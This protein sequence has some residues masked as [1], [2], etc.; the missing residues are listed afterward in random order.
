MNKA[1][2]RALAMIMAVTMV[3]TLIPAETMNA[4]GLGAGKA[5]AAGVMQV[6][7]ADQLSTTSDLD[8]N[9]VLTGKF[10][11]LANS[12]K[13]AAIKK[14]TDVD[15]SYTNST[16]KTFTNTV[17]LTGGGAGTNGNQVVNVIKFSTDAAANGVVYAA[18]KH[19]STNTTRTLKIYKATDNNAS[20]GDAVWTSE[21]TLTAKVMTKFEFSLE[22]AGTYYIGF[23]GDGGIIPYI[24]LE[25]A[26]S[27]IPDPYDPSDIGTTDGVEPSEAGDATWNFPVVAGDR[28]TIEYNG[29]KGNYRGLQIDATTG[30]FAFEA[31]KTHV[32]LTK[33][34]K[35]LVPVSGK[36]EITV[37]A[38]A[39]A[40]YALYTINGEAAS[41][42]EVTS[43]VTYDGEAGYVEIVSTGNAY[44]KS[45][46]VK[47]IDASESVPQNVTITIKDTLNLLDASDKIT[48]V[49]TADAQDVIEVSNGGQVT[50]MTNTTYKAVVQDSEGKE[51]DRVA[52][53][54]GDK[55]TVK[56]TAET[57]AISIDVVSTVVSVTPTITGDELGENKLYAV[58]GSDAMLLKNGEA[59]ILPKNTE[60][61]LVVK[62]AA[63][64][65]LK[66]WVATTSGDS[67]KFNTGTEEILALSV[68][69]QH[70]TDV[71][72]TPVITGKGMLGE[73]KVYMTSEENADGIEV[74]SGQKLTLKALTSYTLVIKTNDGVE[75]KDFEATIAASKVYTTG[76]AAAE[77]TIAVSVPSTKTTPYSKD[78][79]AKVNGGNVTAEEGK[80]LPGTNILY[81]TKAGSGITYDGQLRFRA[82][83]V[84]WLPI[85]A[86]TTRITYIQTS[87]ANQTR[88]VHIGYKDSGYKVQMLSGEASITLDD[89]TDFIVEQ[90]GQK[91]LPLVS[92]ADVKLDT[93]TWVEYNPVNTVKVT[94]TIEGA[95][96]KG[97]TKINFKNMDN[98]DAPIISGT[99]DADGKYSAELRRVAGETKYAASITVIGYKIDDT[100]DADKFTLIGNGATA[101]VNLKLADAPVAKTTGKITGI[102]DAA[103]KGALGVSLIPENE[104]LDPVVLTLTKTDDGY[105][106]A[107]VLLER[108]KSYGVK[109]TNADD[110]EVTVRV[111]IPDA[112]THTV[113]IAATEKAKVEV[114]G[115]FITSDGNDAEVKTI[116][117]TNMETPDY[118]YTFNVTG[119]SYTA[120]LREAEYETSV[121]CK[122]GYTAF[123]HVS[124][125]DANVEN[126]VYIQG[127]VDNT[128]VE[129]KAQ[130]TVGA[131]EGKD[132]AKIADAVAYIA[133]MT[134]TDGQRVTIVLD[135]KATYREQLVINTPNI[136]IQ[137][138]GS[139]ITWYYGVNF[140]YYSAKLS[141]DGKSAYYD[142]AYAVD[143]YNKQA[144]GQNPGHW[145]ATVNLLA[146]A[147]GFAAEDLTFENSL[148]RYLT[149]EELADGA[150]AN[151]AAGV[152][153]R[154][155]ANIDVR[156]KAAKERACVLYI[157]ADNTTYKNCNLLSAQDTL[158]TGDASENSYFVNCKIEGN[159]DYICGDGNA[160]FDQCE[161]SM[162][163]Y[164]DQVAS[165]SYIVAN[166]AKAEHGYFF[167]DCTIIAA[168]D[169]GLKTPVNSYLAR[170]WDAGTC[171]F[172]NTQVYSAEAIIAAGYNDMNAK[173]AD[174]KYYEYNTHLADGSAVDTSKRVATQGGILT[175]DQAAAL[176]M[177]SFFDG[178]KPVYFEGKVKLSKIALT[179]A[180]PVAEEPVNKTATCNT[181]GVTL[182]SFNWYE[183]TSTEAYAEE[184]YK[185]ETD[186]TAKAVISIPDTHEFAAD[187]EVV[188]PGALTATIEK[189]EDGK[190]ATI[191]ATYKTAQAGY[192]VIDLSN[193]LKKGV[194]Y[195]GGISVMDDM[196]LKDGT[197]TVNGT[198]YQW[199][200]GS[201]NPSPNKGEIP[202]TGAVLKLDAKKNG[203]LRVTVADTGG[204][205]VHFVDVV[206]GEK[207]SDIFSSPAEYGNKEYVLN[208]EAGHTY[209]LYGDGTK[210]CLCGTI[211]VDYRVILP[212]PWD[213]IAAPEIVSAKVSETETGIIEVQAKGQVG[214]KGADSMKVVMFDKDGKEVDSKTTTTESN[215]AQTFKFQPTATGSYTFV[216]HLVREGE[217]D[218]VSA[219]S[220]AVEFKLPLATP[221]VQTVTNTG[222]DKDGKGG[223]AIVW[224]AVPEADKY[225][226]TIVDGKDNTKVL[227]TGETKDGSETT[228]TLGGLEIGAY[229]TVSVV[230]CRG[231]ETS[232]AGTKNAYV[233]AE[234]GRP[235]AFS[236][237]G[238]SVSV[239]EKNINDPSKSKNGYLEYEDGSVKVWSTGGAGKVVPGST[240]GLAFYYTKVD[241][242]KE[243]FTLTADVH[244]DSW[245]LSNGQD[246]FGLMV[247]DTIGAMGAG[248][249][250]NNSYQ[251]F[252]TKIEYTWD[253]ENK[254]VTTG[255]D[256]SFRKYSMKLGLGWIAKEGTT[257]TDVG[258]INA[259]TIAMPANFKSTS[260]TLETSAADQGLRKGT[261]NIV[262]N[263]K[264]G[265]TDKD[266]NI[267]TPTVG[268]GITDFKLRIE[269]RKGGYILTY[270]D[271][272]G[273]EFKDEL[274]NGISHQTFYDEDN[275]K[276]TQIDKNNI[277]VGFVASRNAT[278]TVKNIEFK[279]EDFASSEPIV[280][281]ITKINPNYTIISSATSNSAYYDMVFRG[282]A[283]G[284]LNIINETT[285]DSVAL[286]VDVAANQKYT[287][288]TILA[289]GDNKFVISFAPNKDYKPS[290]YEV[291]ANYDTKVFSFHVVYHA[292]TG[293]VIY[294]APDGKS[295]NAGT[296][297]AP[298][299]IYTAI[300]HASAGQKIY[301]A[302]AEY[303]LADLLLIDRGHDGTE[304]EPIYLMADPD[305]T[306]AT[307]PVLN[308][309]N[310]TENKTAFTIAGDYWY[311]KGFDVTRSVDG[312]K[313]VQVSGDY[314]VLEDIKTYENGNTGLQL[315]RY[316]GSDGYADWPSYNTILNCTS[317]L[318][319]DAGYEDA[320]GFAAK[321]TVADG[322]KFVGCIAAYNADDGW[323]LFAK[324]QSGSIG[325]VTIDNCLT[326]K[327]GYLIVDGK[328]ISAGNG[329]G[330][331]MGGD[332][333]PGYHVLKNSVAFGNKAK[334]IDSNSCPDIQVYNSTSYN[335]GSYNVAFY[336][337]NAVNTDFYAENL[338]SFKDEGNRKLHILGKDQTEDDLMVGDQWKLK[339]TQSEIKVNN[340]SYY[341]YNGSKSVNKSG[342][343]AKADWFVSLDMN[344]AINGGIKR[345]ANGS[346]DMGGFLVLKDEYKN[347]GAN[348]TETP[349]DS[350][351]EKTPVVN[352]YAGSVTTLSQ[353]ELPADIKAAGYEWKYP[354]TA[355]AVFAGTRTE[356]IISAKGKA[357]RPAVVNF[358]DVTGVELV[359]DKENL[360]GTDV[361][362]IQ[363]KPV[364]APDV[365]LENVQG[366]AEISYD[367]KEASK[368]KL[369]VVKAEGKNNEVN[370]SRGAD[371]KEGLAKVT[372]AMSVTIGGKTVKKQA[373][374][375]FT[376]RANAFS[377]AYT[378]E[379]AVKDADGSITA[380]AG[381]VIN[382]KDLK[383]TGVGT[384]EAV[385]IS[386]N[387][388]KV[389]KAQGTSVTAVGEG[390]AT[391]TLTAAGNK[392]VV[393]M[394]PVTVRGA[395][396]KT[397]VTN[398]TVDKAKRVGAQIT[399]IACYGSKMDA[400]SVTVKKVLKG[401]NEVDYAKY[402]A[403]TPVIGNIYTISVT[404]TGAAEMPNGTYNV[405][406]EGKNGTVATEFEALIVKVIETKPAVSTKQTKKVN[407]FY[408]AG[409]QVGNGTLTATSKQ[410]K[411]TLTQKD[412]DSADFRLDR[413]GSK[414]TIVLKGSAADK[415]R[416]NTKITV[417]ASFDGYK[418]SYNK[419]LTINVGT[420]NKAPKL[421]LEVDN[422]ILYTKI[423]ITDTELRILDTATNTYVTGATVKLADSTTS[424]QKANTNFTL[425]EEN[426]AY[427]L[428]TS[429][430]GSAKIY[431][432]DADWTKELILSQ[433]LTVNTK[434]PK[435]TFAAV[436]L[437]NEDQFVG[438]EQAASVITV[439]N[440]LDYQVQNLTLTGANAKSTEILKYLDYSVVV[441][442][443]GQNVLLISAKSGENG[444]P[445]GTKGAFNFKA[446]FALN[447]LTEQ[448]A[449]VKLT[450]VDKSAITTS[451]KGS[452]DLVNRTGTSITM[453]PVLKNVNGKIVGMALSE[454]ASNQFDI[455]WDSAQ[456]AAVVT[457]KEWVD[458]KK[459]GKYK[460]TPVFQVETA[461]GIVDVAAKTVTISP[462]QSKIKTSKLAVQ[463]LRLSS[464]GTSAKATL[465]A[466]SPAKAEILDMTQ[467]T[468]NDK[469][470]VTYDAQSDTVTVRLVDTRGLKANSTYKITMELE[471]KDYSVNTKKQTI[472]IPVKVVK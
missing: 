138:N 393:E 301:L 107:E 117:F 287:A 20:L 147:A 456:G 340:D 269:R 266:G 239:D 209:Y 62:N 258:Q 161:L 430:S 432:K 295:T 385:K 191:T 324:V 156:A 373:T 379:G 29:T 234:A 220:A 372:A 129:Y 232:E 61:S 140:S 94:G 110:Y 2:R 137:G 51:K 286:D 455:V 250:W 202:T 411:V 403:V 190:T 264:G 457:A 42:S 255:E 226:V 354:N 281:E 238:S 184:T 443:K 423:G 162:Y 351:L 363:A 89:I 381:D 370:V 23:S 30:K 383:V 294:V 114:K 394:I 254:T 335:N 70:V 106:F 341:T 424:Y 275:N 46:A 244:V 85:Q 176:D 59:V 460:V 45:I 256:D 125:K 342:D 139:T 144:I 416:K 52:A 54:I 235:W 247:A 467:K 112:E 99:V 412:A 384:N 118:T 160:V 66:D 243:A 409:T 16:D 92:D 404:D 463:E 371:S 332:S 149:Q 104:A 308:F 183:G 57:T 120:N 449:N 24:S 466:T 200:Q 71:E 189:S 446:T 9:T 84:L 426:G 203:K 296:K 34:A 267:T 134:R 410:G 213:K 36:C 374:Y 13:K 406:L 273:N 365:A 440:A 461:G 171:Y 408:T 336:T 123:D 225:K 436:K 291:M 227:A 10:S 212:D 27:T 233:K 76:V 402:F 257:Q 194:N 153:P 55:S 396:Y 248:T 124:V 154:T 284:K 81:K 1:M 170:A 103:I 68:A 187:V 72:I 164:T 77:V 398:I 39:G 98:P 359:A 211:I 442:D 231:E 318:N 75:V 322:N 44:I 242:Q 175:A 271:K 219:A 131:G 167:K 245:N 358:I 3:V 241:P 378:L 127:P 304:E 18:L 376:T 146:G 133:R 22:E 40:Q 437:N 362:K 405:I 450:F 395:S 347:K 447:T 321:L 445:K 333:M 311:L 289:E 168:A 315:S 280:R 181:D 148:N 331:K 128:P 263:N 65:E 178:W 14:I 173:A 305:D 116:T 165:G 63:G 343:E 8:T 268:E 174:A 6:L 121:T 377:F 88:Y 5:E 387:D 288:G 108:N 355:T 7:D 240:D 17:R 102:P 391:I 69:I 283:D 346:I 338:I 282:N 172:I 25:T 328:E 150:G 28:D 78:T 215:D 316:L 422:Q 337:N 419:E 177:T 320:D 386:V 223:F 130:I 465:K 91:Y 252:S 201:V 222:A 334:G 41:T 221:K 464:Y 453:K 111:E 80:V 389:L 90:D 415:T 441:N 448:T 86:D 368:L 339:G 472:T 349:A 251:L 119:T 122:D 350:I 319:A 158:Y 329:N 56:V 142:E 300:A 434:D 169:E 344:A 293:D 31:N 115:N 193:G 285:G 196:P 95:A 60:Y 407:L 217:E 185:G 366:T 214:G 101:E 345:T 253:P 132:F 136:T 413:S 427:V 83:N 37:T 64:E 325:V 420:E 290:Q 143:K 360:V 159:T 392:T 382:F 302:K 67:S 224:G 399:A 35:I 205:L 421:K 314:N 207:Q 435:A 157:Q 444:L 206:N 330:F 352:V 198:D 163:G 26:G 74:I 33:D 369:S 278:I 452:I 228:I 261:Y 87:N 438:K 210:I 50:L 11:V 279:S 470:V 192:Y 19:S 469:F 265:L 307:R 259:G 454:D 306:A 425:K 113:N 459:G 367:I 12:S 208:V 135:E 249:T 297:D 204:K 166:K 47:H 246:G 327:N 326:F 236:A 276:L 48:L 216:A 361:L 272:D 229:V 197:K 186:Y 418:D 451:Q 364:V 356:F 429:K 21:S 401:K 428:G 105:S 292:L 313:G 274:G 195:D 145:G 439:K 82:D 317:Y 299:D 323:D 462:K 49:N 155:T 431:V 97:I 397:N 357:D 303:D 141:A 417:I 38:S 388:T 199:V 433:S 414:Y 270:L 58:K 152:T 380:N 298:L 277:Y 471:V 400:G 188:V 260:G 230:A 309:K 96:G 73:N 237:F 468:L 109:L 353:V 458:L 182:T 151:T 179:I 43:T 218:K 390:T 262:G 312:Q 310:M 4:L 15:A 93:I 53:M 100:N 32:Q 348:V 79:F 180:A 126:D 375:S